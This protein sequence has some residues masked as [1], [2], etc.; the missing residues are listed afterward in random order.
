MGSTGTFWLETFF[1]KT[2]D[3]LDMQAI[4]PLGCYQ[5]LE[6]VG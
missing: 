6:K 3:L 5:D 1:V 2:W 4:M